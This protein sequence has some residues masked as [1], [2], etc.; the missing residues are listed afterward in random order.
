MPKAEKHISVWAGM[1]LALL[2]ILCFPQAQAQTL[3]WEELSFDANAAHVDLGESAV[4]DWDAFCAFLDGFETLESVDMFGTKIGREEI[5]LLSQRYPD[6]SFGWTMKFAEHTVRTDAT[7]FST[8]HYSGEPEH[9]SVD[10]SILKYCENLRALDIGH[11]AAK[12]LS[13]L[14]DLPELRVLIIACNKVEDLTPLA[15]LKH[16]EYLEM[17]SNWVEDLTPL[18]ELPY[19][20]HLN[21]GY[22]NITD[23][24]PLHQMPQLKRLWMKKSHSRAKA[25]AIDKSIIADLQEALPD[26]L[27]DYV[28]NPSEGGWRES[29][30]FET[31]HEYFRT[32]E[33]RP[34][35]DSPEENR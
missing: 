30:Y 5:E 1:V 15:S 18:E 13:F 19:L 29:I 28:S 27:I 4:K 31:F 26:C 17:F 33:Y 11:N 8:L 22:N 21:I 6:V 2:M 24:T 23:Y 25:P 32:G 12:D 20:A 34:F 7:A 35:P 3:S 16:L 14:Y 9:T 10:F